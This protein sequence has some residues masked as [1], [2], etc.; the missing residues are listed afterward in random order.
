MGRRPAEPDWLID[1]EIVYYRD[2]C[3]WDWEAVGTF[4][5]MSGKTAQRRYAR[6]KASRGREAAVEQ[7]EG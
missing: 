5:G 7:V 4:F 1:A 3:R 6:L 2:Q